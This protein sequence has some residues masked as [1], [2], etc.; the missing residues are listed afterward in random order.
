MSHSHIGVPSTFYK[1]LDIVW[2]FTLH[3]KHQTHGQGPRLS[4][5]YLGGKLFIFFF[6]PRQS[7]E[8][9]KENQVLMETGNDYEE[10]QRRIRRYD[11]N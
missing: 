7:D 4:I 8:I 2:V 5:A 6:P 9:L 11:W 1:D 3:T 10:Q